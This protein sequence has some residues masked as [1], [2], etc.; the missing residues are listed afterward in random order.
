M[1][2][3]ENTGDP[4]MK[5]WYQKIFFLSAFLFCLLALCGCGKHYSRSDA[6]RWFRQQVL[7]EKIVVS[8]NHL[9]QENRDGY[10]DRI[11]IAYLADL[12]E[13]EFKLISHQYYSLFPASS[14]ETTYH[15]EMGKYYLRN[16]Q[17]QYP[18]GL[19]DVQCQQLSDLLSVGKLYDNAAEIETVCLQLEHLND[20]I[21]QQEYPC[22]IRF[23]IAFRE[24]QTFVADSDADTLSSHDSYVYLYNDDEELTEDG[25]SAVLEQKAKDALAKYAAAYRLET[26]QVG[27]EQM[28]QAVIRNSK[29]RFSITRADGLLL[30][31]PDL[32]LAHNGAMS[33]GCL[34]EVLLREGTYQ[35]TGTPEKFSFVTAD[36][37]TC[38]FSY[39]YREASKTVSDNSKA[40]FFYYV[41]N[42]EKIILSGRPF[43]DNDHFL[44]LTGSSFK[45]LRN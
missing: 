45:T 33:F 19:E 18:Y 29:N 5:K 25:L 26:E 22:R 17:E 44:S 28:E 10:T 40:E 34:Y 39:S 41:V 21:S 31:Y 4:I 14:M 32:I 30:C 20:Y 11:W 6:A 36:G 2:C 8:G 1:E 43:I 16:Y 35:L 15:L 38:S 23:G 42:G 27:E 9:D 13:V 37:L 12:P 24:P 7:D 3:P